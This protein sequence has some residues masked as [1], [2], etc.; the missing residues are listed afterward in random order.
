MRS[1]LKNHYSPAHGC[2]KGRVVLGPG[3]LGI[4]RHGNASRIE[5]HWRAAG[6]PAILGRAGV[7]SVPIRSSILAMTVCRFSTFALTS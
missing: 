6:F 2:R 1:T 4:T 5:M 3:A 7:V